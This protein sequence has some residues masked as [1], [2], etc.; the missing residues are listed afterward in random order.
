MFG[1]RSRVF[2]NWQNAEKKGMAKLPLVIIDRT[3]YARSNERLNNM[4]NEVKYEVTSK[5]RIAELL[6]PV[7]I[8]ISYDVSV[9]A[10]YPSDID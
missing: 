6:T 7:P 3:G 2:K 5:S 8:D 1:Q 4:H 9:V 10:K